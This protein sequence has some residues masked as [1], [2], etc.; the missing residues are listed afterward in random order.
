M[1]KNIL[2]SRIVRGVSCKGSGDI[3][4]IQTNNDPSITAFSVNVGSKDVIV[5]KSLSTTTLQ[6]KKLAT[7]EV[8]G[9]G[10]AQVIDLDKDITIFEN[11]SAATA[12]L[13]PGTDGQVKYVSKTTTGGGGKTVTITKF[14]GGDLVGA[15]KVSVRLD[16]AGSGATLV[17]NTAQGLWCLA[18]SCDVTLA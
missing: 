17:Y 10:L 9:N 13:A 3:L 5:S 12:T 2:A 7:S 6:G 4:N 11:T 16:D 15:S 1:T 8:L 18:G 14:G